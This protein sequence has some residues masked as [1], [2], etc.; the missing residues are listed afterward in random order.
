M[1]RKSSI[2][3][4]FIPVI[5]GCGLF[6]GLPQLSPQTPGE[7]A[8]GYTYIPIDPI[9]ISEQ[10]GRSCGSEEAD[11][12]ETRDI[13]TFRYSPR[14]QNPTENTETEI[15]YKSLLD[16]FPDNAV[17]ISLEQFDA[18]GA[19]SYGQ[20]G[21][22]A[23]GGI[24]RVTVDYINA[25][26]RTFPLL[27]RKTVNQLKIP[28]SEP[29]ADTNETVLYEV[30]VSPFINEPTTND[31]IEVAQKDVD[32]LIGSGYEAFNLP[33]YIGIGLRITA[34][35][36]VLK[37]NAKIEGLGIIGAEAEA[38]RLQGSLVVQT[39]GVNGKSISAALPIQ[40]ELNRT[41][42]QNAIVAIGS[43]KALLYEDE[44]VISPRVVGLYLP[45][46]GG[47]ALVNQIISVLSKQSPI[48]WNRPCERRLDA[49]GRQLVQPSG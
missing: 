32:Q 5:S 46:P 48:N 11:V 37:A 28:I 16:S 23:K 21:I 38:G 29:I 20:S 25:D 30:E 13:E 6:S 12:L 27:I 49:L 15:V 4:L 17:R 22:G 7:E 41:T 47:R 2:G 33:L 1:N 8:S 43:I 19:V 45:F 18:K 36:Q 3:C 42:A 35:V 9:A 34:N 14:T 26:T 39:L 31:E 10:P 40:S 44:T 24:Y